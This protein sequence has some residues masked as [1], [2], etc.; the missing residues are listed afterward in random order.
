MGINELVFA[1][2]LSEIELT[3]HLKVCKLMTY[4]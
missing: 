1:S 3:G 2:E 4:V